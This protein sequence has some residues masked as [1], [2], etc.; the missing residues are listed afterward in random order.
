MLKF[1]IVGM[2]IRGNLFADTLAENQY[3]QLEAICDVSEKNL[4]MAAD[5]Y[6]VKACSDYREMMDSSKLDSVIITTPD[7]LHRDPVIYAANKGLHIMVEK[8]FSTSSA[9]CREMVDAIEKNKVSCLVAFENRWNFP[10][11]A[12]KE[13]IEN[14]EIGDVLTMNAR[15]NDTIFVP[16][17][18]LSWAKNST[19]GWFLFPHI[20]D[21]ACWFNGKEVKKVYATGLKK[22]LVSMGYDTYDSIQAVLTFDDGTNS[23]F[24]SSWILPDTMPLIYDLKFEIIGEEGALYLDTQNQM[25]RQAGKKY[26]HVHTI[27][28]SVNGKL[29]AAPCYMLHSFVDALREGK[30]P[31][32]TEIDGLKNTLVVEAVHKSIE[33]GRIIEV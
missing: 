18:L 16:T 32:T 12:V 5:K 25:L 20:I 22:K 7:F 33:T 24:T 23:T 6:K 10:M 8:P 26:S 31:S 14:G 21:L 29:T 11:L 28:T 1:G 3:A 2:G 27:G 15:L 30:K 9:E 13:R 17:K 19:V 4:K